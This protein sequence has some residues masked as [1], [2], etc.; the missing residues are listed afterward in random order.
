[1]DEFSVYLIWNVIII[2][3]SHDKY[4]CIYF[5]LLQSMISTQWYKIQQIMRNNEA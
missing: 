2:Y 4:V 5:F 3:T 1:M